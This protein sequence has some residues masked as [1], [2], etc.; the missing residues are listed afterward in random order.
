MMAAFKLS[1]RWLVLVLLVVLVL[2]VVPAAQ[3]S[4][5]AIF[6]RFVDDG[7]AQFHCN[8]AP[9]YVFIEFEATVEHQ[10]LL[11]V[12]RVDELRPFHGDVIL[13]TYSQ[14]HLIN[15]FGEEQGVPIG[16]GT[17]V[18]SSYPITAEWKFRTIVG[19][20][21]VYESSLSATCPSAGSWPVTVQNREITSSTG[22]TSDTGTSSQANECLSSVPASSV[23]GRILQTT[24]AYFAPDAG[25]ATNIIIPAGTAWWI[26]DTRSGFYKLFIACAANPVWVPAN[27]VGPNFDTGG[28]PLPDARTSASS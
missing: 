7:T 8:D 12:E 3:A 24:P 18:T 20:S 10:N 9:D 27:V 25:S 14:S 5:S 2:Y 6:L 21:V 13:Y 26:L 22:S 1:K 16:V 4:D 15:L 17:S 19:G 23:Q 28:A 11:A